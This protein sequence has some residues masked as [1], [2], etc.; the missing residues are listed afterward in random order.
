[1]G[2]PDKGDKKKRWAGEKGKKVQKKSG[3][4]SGWRRTKVARRGIK[5]IT[6]NHIRKV[7]EPNDKGEHQRRGIY[8]RTKKT[9]VRGKK[10]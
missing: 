7:T 5:E 4:C 8:E 6:H 2:S 10:E 9:E 1:V 3:S